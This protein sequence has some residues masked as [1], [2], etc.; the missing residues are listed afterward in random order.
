MT[1]IPHTSHDWKPGMVSPTCKACGCVQ[2][3]PTARLQCRAVES[4]G[5]NPY[6]VT[7]DLQ[8]QHAEGIKAAVASLNN[9]IANAAE[10][11]VVTSIEVH[12][13]TTFG[14]NGRVV[15]LTAECVALL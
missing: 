2:D 13:A 3:S 9:L 8:K 12:D 15:R 5:G 7:Q 10:N 1:Y 11:N 6:P 4:D 14:S